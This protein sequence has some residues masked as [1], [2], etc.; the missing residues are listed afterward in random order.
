MLPLTRRETL[1]GLAA[2]GA[3]PLLSKPLRRWRRSRNRS[4]GQA[5]CSTSIAENLLRL[6][7][8]KRDFARH[9]QGRPRVAAFAARATAPPRASSA[10]RRPSSADLARAEAVDTSRL[11]FP[12]RTSVEVVQERL[13]HGARGLRPALRRRRRR[14][15]AQ[16]ALCRDPECRRLHRHSA[17]PRHRPSDRESRRRRGLSHPAR[18]I[19]RG[20]STASSGGCGPRARKGLVPPDFLIDKALDQLGIALK[21]ARA[22]R[23]PRRIAR[24]PD[25][26]EGHPGRLGRARPQDRHAAKSRPRCSARSRSCRPS[27]PSPPTSPAC[28]RGRTARNIIAGRSRPRR[29]P[30]CRPTRSTRWASSSSRSCRGGWTRS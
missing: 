13:P 28:G 29:R 30:T 23:R 21:N 20:S 22:G 5:R 1:A 15:L 4:P 10:S 27:A 14:R 25:Q 19:S 24:P 2:T 26:G 3:L 6:Y 11:S 8:E 9:R 17:V 7:P 12:A 16:H 18:A